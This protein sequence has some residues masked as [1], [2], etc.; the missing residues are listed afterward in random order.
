MKRSL[1]YE[2]I[3]PIFLVGALAA[4][5]AV[6]FT[7]RSFLAQAREQSLLRAEALVH[8]INYAA[9][10]LRD[11]ADLQRFVMAL[12]AESDV[13]MVIV[14]GGASSPEEP[15]RVI[16]STDFGW[17]G[18]LVAELPV[19]LHHSDIDA[20]IR[21]RID[22]YRRLDASDHLY[23][24][25]P[26][27]LSD[28][29]HASSPLANSAVALRLDTSAMTRKSRLAW[30][31][32]IVGIA[33]LAVVLIALAIFLLRHFVLRPLGS[34]SQAMERRAAGDDSAYADIHNHDELGRLAKELN[35]TLDVLADKERQF[36]SLVSNIPGITY[37]CVWQDGWRLRFMSEHVAAVT[38]YPRDEFLADPPRAY[39][40]LAHPDDAAML[41]Y[42]TERAV[43]D[44]HPLSVEYRVIR[45][46]GTERW[47]HETAQA[48]YN[49]AGRPMFLDGF[50]LDITERR[51][52]ELLL[53]EAKAAAEEATRV[54]GEF[55]ATMSHE[56]R[57]PLNG[58]VGMATLLLDTELNHEQQE[59]AE[60]INSCSDAL[61]VTI[62]DILDFS[63]IEAGK[64]TLEHTEMSLRHVIEEI[65]TL[66]G[67][68]AEEKG[69]A[70][71]WQ[72]ARTIP[73]TLMG[74]P[75]RV[76]Q[77]LLNLV[78]N[79]I[80]FTHQGSVRI[81]V[82][83]VKADGDDL[84]IE[85]AVTDTGIGL[86]REVMSRIFEPFSQADSST[87]R[88]YGGTGLGLT[89]CK[90][91]VEQMGG[92]ISVESKEGKGATFSFTASFSRAASVRAGDE[93]QAGERDARGQSTLGSRRFD[94]MSRAA[95]SGRQILLVEDNEVNQRTVGRM[96]RRLQYKVKVVGN[97][98]EAIAAVE[99]EDYDLV[100][101]DCEMPVMDGFETTAWLRENR[102]RDL[103]IIALTA[104]AL[105]GDRERTLVAGMDEYLS[106]PVRLGTLAKT[107]ARWL[108]DGSSSAP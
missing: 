40:E 90:R 49:A 74:D 34:I 15:A 24:A 14:A 3:V 28:R 11:P 54:K 39:R 93:R 44:K 108:P 92:V 9:E 67:G 75:G 73:G 27:L 5:S 48:T 102:G 82:D 51:S 100:L 80:K 16:A 8:S 68:R 23:F 30:L 37:R 66:L 4:G 41:S 53:R 45:A 65:I 59:Y 87:T 19:E 84:S 36:R 12:G 10:S 96:L 62:N 85:I 26:L 77:V 99:R 2:L 13:E 107:I 86:T 20:L 94:T 1:R 91:L 104:A 81:L 25:S 63:R 106:K 7:Q 69:L 57:T 35:R 50:I 38:G 105:P 42:A 97:G 56:I 64:L 29:G 43:E 103:P 89:I 79:A 33:G 22:V 101:M 83:L 88:K 78:G 71:S 61:L 60:T 72:I 32:S 21:G 58:V 70:L 52:Q 46:D 18:M 98:L 17:R 31:Y 6:Y 76:R 95:S 47:V 55:L